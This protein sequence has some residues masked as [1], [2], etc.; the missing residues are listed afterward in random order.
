MEKP[1]V[2]VAASWY[3]C[4][5]LAA[6]IW[7]IREPHVHSFARCNI[8]LVHGTERNLVIDSGTG[9]LPLRSILPGIDDRPVVAVATHIHFDHVG[10]LHE[11]SD[12]R[13]HDSELQAFA[14]MPDDVT[15]AHLF[16]D[17]NEPVT[18]LPNTGWTPDRYG[19]RPAPI[20]TTLA[21]GD[22]IDLGNRSL[23]VMHVPGHSRDSIALFEERTGI[24]FSGDALY[25][26]ELIDTF[27]SSNL[28]R[29][30]TT[31]FSLKALEISLGHGGHGPSFSN[32]RKNVLV[33]EYLAGRRA[34]G[35][36]HGVQPLSGA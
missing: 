10:A 29:Y 18:Q 8:W 19:L 31:M 28:D 36:P 5:K 25:D 13:A 16:R 14:T 30:R 20:G 32:A 11:F 22:R 33:D 3:E 15:L 24:L 6:G 34:Q 21:D 9:L 4:H 26:G 1:N 7:R 12:R 23:S 27:P 2:H 17:L 35:C